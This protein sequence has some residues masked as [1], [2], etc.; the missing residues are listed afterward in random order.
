MRIAIAFTLTFL[1]CLPGTASAAPAARQTFKVAVAEGKAKQSAAETFAHFFKQMNASPKYAFEVV[2]FADGEKQYQAIKDGKVDL[3]FLGPASYVKAR[4]EFKAEPVAAEAGDLR[5]LLVVAK[6]SPIRSVKELR[7]KTLALGYEGSTTTHLLPML[8][9]SKHQ[10][11][12]EDMGRVI[13]LGDSTRKIVQ[14]VLDGTAAAGGI[15]ENL[16]AAHK[17]ELRA[18]E[19]SEALPGALIAA[20]P[21]VP[22]AV[23]KDLRALFATYVP[24]PGSLRFARGAVAVTDDAYNR[25]RFLCKVVLGRMYL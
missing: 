6:S 20:H 1:F 23:V 17:H 19:T 5:S 15:S 10:L 11:K 4:Y 8:L 25:V 12:R 14:A 18:L 13:F 3:A 21:K 16:Y 9:L 24:A 22:A 2:V 7:G